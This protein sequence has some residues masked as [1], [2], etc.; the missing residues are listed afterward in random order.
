MRKDEKDFLQ[1]LLAA[2]GTSGYETSVSKVW[3]GRVSKYADKVETD[4]L[5]N[6]IATL[7]PSGS[8]KILLAGHADEIGFQV[9]HIDDNG[10]ISFNLV[11]GHDRSLIPGRRVIVHTEKGPVRGVTGKKA[12]HLMTDEEKKSIP[13]VEEMWI[14][15]GAK[16]K[17]EAA[18]LV[19]IGDSVTHD[20]GYQE[21]RNDLI[22]SRALDDRAGAFVAAETLIALAKSKRKLKVC[23]V[24]VATAQEEIGARG[25]ATSTY[26]VAPDVGICIDVTHATDSP[27]ID[28]RKVGETKLGGGPRLPRGASVNDGV[29]RALCIAG[30]KAQVAYQIGAQ[31]GVAPNDTRSIQ[32]AR[33]GVATGT[34][35][36][37][38]RY[39][40]TPSEMASLK[41][42]EA[43]VKLLAEFCLSLDGKVKFIPS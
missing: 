39:M 26:G 37:P 23:V 29:F 25:A 14:D 24:A 30:D 5:G 27:G 38:L 28:L 40:H 33:S 21:L 32:L 9:T 19:R 35:G 1:A 20:A 3:R 11:G 12:I 10:F 43:S 16:S 42:L 41:D 7:N 22:V 17:K 31:P 15:L 18:S 13:Q 4:T 34:V 2:H 8:P 6:S 36:L